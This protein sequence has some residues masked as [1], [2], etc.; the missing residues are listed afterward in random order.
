M[1][2]QILKKINFYNSIYVLYYPLCMEYGPVVQLDRTGRYGRLGW[3]FE[4]LRV[5]QKSKNSHDARI[6]PTSKS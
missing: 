1:K 3:G 6:T 5:L 4:F 2:K